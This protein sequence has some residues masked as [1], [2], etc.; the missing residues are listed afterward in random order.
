[1]DTRCVRS[2]SRSV[3]T[4][5]STSTF[6]SS[7]SETSSFPSS[8]ESTRRL[9]STVKQEHFSFQRPSILASFC[10]RS[11]SIAAHRSWTS[12][13]SLAGLGSRASRQTLKHGWSCG[14]SASIPARPRPQQSASATHCIF[15]SSESA[16]RVAAARFAPAVSCVPCARASSWWQQM[17]S[18]ADMRRHSAFCSM[19]ELPCGSSGNISAA[20]LAIVV[21]ILV[22]H[23][24]EHALVQHDRRQHAQHQPIQMDKDLIVCQHHG[25]KYGKA[26]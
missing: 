23:E 25:C 12:P 8:L 18:P 4:A 3:I 17:S 2:I 26:R 9:T 22:H 15:A 14:R 20:A 6:S 1:M 5:A 11:A 13:C 24:V 7:Q 21:L 19:K 16:K 10:F